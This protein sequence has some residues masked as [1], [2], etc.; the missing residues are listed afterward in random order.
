MEVWQ[1]G[2]KTFLVLNSNEYEISTA[3][4]NKNTDK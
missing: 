4:K 1:R 2:Y 3:H